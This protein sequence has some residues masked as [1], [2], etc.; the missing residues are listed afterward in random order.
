M[1]WESE[2]WREAGGGAERVGPSS[3]CRDAAS[4]E[5]GGWQP[6]PSFQPGTLMPCNS[7]FFLDTAVASFL[8]CPFSGREIFLPKPC[9]KE[10]T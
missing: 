5:T 8:P 9:Q 10:L 6:V 2:G 3:D 4:L 7:C 1:A